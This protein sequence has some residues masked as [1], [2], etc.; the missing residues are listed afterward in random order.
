MKNITN[1]IGETAQQFRAFVALGQ[2]LV[3]VPSTHFVAH[4]NLDAGSRRSNALF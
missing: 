1:G 3:S 2:N 4:S